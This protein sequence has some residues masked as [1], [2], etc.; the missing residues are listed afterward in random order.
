MK[1]IFMAAICCMVA[2]AT[3]AREVTY[4]VYYN[5]IINTRGELYLYSERYLGTTDVVMADSH[6]FV[7]DKIKRVSPTTTTTTTTTS[8]ATWK[9]QE[10]TSVK[11]Q[12]PLSEE[13]LMAT[14]MAKKAESVAKQIY[15]IR[16]TRMNILSG[17]V[18]HMPADGKAMQ[19]VLDEL[20]KQEEA[21]TSMFVGTSTIKTHR[22]S[23]TILVSDTDKAIQQPLLK[24]S[25]EQGP[26]DAQDKSGDVIT[27]NIIRTTEPVLAPVQP[28][29]GGPVYEDKIISSKI[30]I[31][32]QNKIIYEKTCNL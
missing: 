2:M 32:Y 3:E 10:K 16:E 18:E 6:T 14:N 30:S 23:V 21:L 15:R 13:T 12:L 25:K 27:L 11:A 7:L 28:K 4:N 5:E 1:K 17:D 31:T 8:T 29:K 20:N 26:M 9:A 19:L 22:K 24:F